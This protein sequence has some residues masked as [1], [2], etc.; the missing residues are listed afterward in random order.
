MKKHIILF[1]LLAV[2][3]FAHA[4]ESPAL[5]KELRH[6]VSL[7]IGFFTEP[8][9]YSYYNRHKVETEGDGGEFSPVYSLHVQYFYKLSKNIDIGGTIGYCNDNSRAVGFELD[10]NGDRISNGLFK[11]DSKVMYVM[12]LVRYSW[13]AAN[14]YAF[15]SK[16]GAGLWYIRTS[17]NS[18]I[19]GKETLHDKQLAYQITFLGVKASNVRF[20]TYFEIGCGCQGIFVFGCTLNL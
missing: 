20:G 1:V 12:P 13:I 4:Q 7:G 9:N 18:E 15:Y 19:F 6:E 2:S 3:V 8:R 10:K 17:T 11:F 14:K 16:A 5:K